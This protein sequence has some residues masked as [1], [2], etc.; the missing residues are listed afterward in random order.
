MNEAEKRA[1]QNAFDVIEDVVTIQDTCMKIT[2]VNRAAEQ[3]FELD[4]GQLIGKCCYQVF[5]GEKQP[6]SGCPDWRLAKQHLVHASEVENRATNKTLQLTAFS[7][8]DE[9]GV[10]K[11]VIHFAKDITRLKQRDLEFRQFRMSEAVGTLARGLVHDF[12]NLLFPIIGYT[13]MALGMMS[14][15]STP[16]KY[17]EKILISVDRMKELLLQIRFFSSRAETETMPLEIEPV[18]KR[19]L[20]KMKTDLPS[21]VSVHQNMESNCGSILA[22]PVQLHQAMQHLF[23]NAS[24]SMTEKGGVLG[25]CLKQVGLHSDVM[26]VDPDLPPGN[27]LKLTVSDTGYGMEPEVMERIFDPYYTTKEK[28]KGI[29]LGLSQVQGIIHNHGGKITVQSKQGQGTTFDIYLPELESPGGTAE[30]QV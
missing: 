3:L 30:Q 26:D 9:N 16:S 1:W 2:A 13:E 4:A 19:A 7:I 18:I 5:S 11:G 27:Y 6:C 12:N 20:N 21:N 10:F 25:I 14:V 15:D 29:G 28:G 17:L 22:D 24:H 23:I 8:F